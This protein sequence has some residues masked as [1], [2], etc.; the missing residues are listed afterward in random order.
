M[1]PGTIALQPPLAVWLA[2]NPT[3]ALSGEAWP[4]RAFVFLG[5]GS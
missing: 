4:E 5:C 3:K 1:G 2:H